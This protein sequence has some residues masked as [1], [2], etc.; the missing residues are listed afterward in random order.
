MSVY[1]GTL[2]YIVIQ[3]FVFSAFNDQFEKLYRTLERVF[4]QVYK[5]SFSVYHINKNETKVKTYYVQMA[6]IS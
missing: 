6:S 3:E 5:H 2:K 4:H 1:V